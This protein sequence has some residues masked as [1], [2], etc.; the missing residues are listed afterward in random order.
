MGKDSDTPVE[1]VWSDRTL[2][3]AATIWELE[4]ADAKCT[5]RAQRIIFDKHWH[6]WNQAKADAS[7]DTTCELCGE[8]DSLKYLLVEC[9][10]PHYKEIRDECLAT[11][12]YNACGQRNRSTCLKRNVHMGI[13][14]VHMGIKPLV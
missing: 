5:A 9:Q 11:I 12:R 14:P 3:H 7:I 8:G 13:K 1:A 2:Q 4:T 6:S 10:H